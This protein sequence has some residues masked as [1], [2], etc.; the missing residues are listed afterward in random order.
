MPEPIVRVE[1][2]RQFRAALRRADGDLADLKAVNADVA[3][4]AA[5]AGRIDAPHRSGALAATVRSS[6]TA[7]QAIVRVGTSRVPYAGPI[8]YGWPA[9]HI[10]PHPFIITGAESSQPAWLDLY[11]AAIDRIVAR[12][13]RESHP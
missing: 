7:T 6:G 12:I 11:V 8:H 4:V 5:R 1:G 2:A 13:E 10:A 3:A 9:R